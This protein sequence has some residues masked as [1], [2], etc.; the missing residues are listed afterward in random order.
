[1]GTELMTDLSDHPLASKSG[2]CHIPQCVENEDVC[3]LERIY[4]KYNTEAISELTP[5]GTQGPFLNIDNGI[6]D[7]YAYW[8]F[9]CSHPQCVENE[10]ECVLER[11]HI[12]YNTEAISELTHAGIQGPFLNIDN[13]IPDHYAYLALNCSTPDN[14]LNPAFCEEAIFP[15]LAISGS[16]AG[17]HWDARQSQIFW[18]SPCG[19]LWLV[20]AQNILGMHLHP[21]QLKCLQILCGTTS[22]T[23]P[24]LTWLPAGTRCRV[25]TRVTVVGRIHS[26]IPPRLARGK[27]S[28]QVIWM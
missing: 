13:G 21:V 6:P 8:A 24:T 18:I 9:N 25:V 10:D 22:W 28:K 4:I 12:K 17:I 1:M 27:L 3:V 23:S 16:E 26:Q 2:S 7:Y 11:I 20:V 19:I 15:R 5:A 14:T